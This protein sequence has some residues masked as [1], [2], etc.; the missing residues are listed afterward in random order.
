MVLLIFLQ[1]H[2]QQKFR[3]I[4]T[5]VPSRAPMKLMSQVEYYKPELLLWELILHLRFMRGGEI[6]SPLI[7]TYLC[8]ELSRILRRENV[9]GAL[10]LDTMIPLVGHIVIN[11]YKLPKI[12]QRNN[13]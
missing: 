9:I 7:W 12:C 13:R 1:F 6:V 10:I 11:V 3:K 2:C 4:V 5:K 8:S